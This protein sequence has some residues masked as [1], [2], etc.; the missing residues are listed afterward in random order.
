MINTPAPQTTP[1]PAH[2][3]LP[4]IQSVYLKY[5]WLV[6]TSNPRYLT[7]RLVFQAELQVPR[8]SQINPKKYHYF[9][10]R[11]SETQ[12]WCGACS[13]SPSKSLNLVDLSPCSKPN[14]SFSVLYKC[15]P[16]ALISFLISS[17]SFLFLKFSLTPPKPH[18]RTWIHFPNEQFLFP[19]QWVP[20]TANNF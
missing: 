5:L 7:T 19:S 17:T 9:R 12:R 14:M 20:T 10:S 16:Y 2:A 3:V 18:P 6:F 8:T 13:G 1:T 4:L 15:P 11:A